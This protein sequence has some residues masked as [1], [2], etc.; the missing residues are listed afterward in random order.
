LIRFH[1]LHQEFYFEQQR[2]CTRFCEEGGSLQ[3]PISHSK[4]CKLTEELAKER[5]RFAAN[6]KAEAYWL[7]ED[8]LQQFELG[9]AQPLA[10]LTN[11]TATVVKGTR[12]A[13]KDPCSGDADKNEMVV[14][15]QG[16][17]ETLSFLKMIPPLI[18]QGYP[19]GCCKDPAVPRSNLC[20]R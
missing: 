1:P 20:K 11:N 2:D 18:L 8:G 6:T 16:V 19:M 17:F 12:E 4:N 15:L 14:V 13:G 9:N 10:L 5:Y 3:E 7:L